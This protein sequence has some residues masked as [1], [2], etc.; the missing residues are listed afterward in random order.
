MN[1]TPPTETL[2]LAL[3][4]SG[5]SVAH[6]GFDDDDELFVSPFIGKAIV[7]RHPGRFA[8]VHIFGTIG[9]GWASLYLDSLAPDGEDEAEMKN[10]TDA[11]EKRLKGFGE[12]AWRGYLMEVGRAFE[13]CTGVPTQCHL[14]PEGNTNEEMWSILQ[15]MASLGLGRGRVAVDVTHS[16]R[17]L[18]LFFFAILLYFNALDD[19]VELGEVFY[20]KYAK[21]PSRSVILRL[22]ALLDLTRWTDAAQ[23]LRTYGDAGPLAALMPGT[24]IAEAAELFSLALMGNAA[25]SIRASAQ[26]L[27]DALA[28]HPLGD[29]PAF[30]LVR[31]RLQD[32]PARLADAPSDWE[33]MLLVSEH[34]LATRRYAL[35]ILNLWEAG[36]VR[37]AEVVGLQRLE[38]DDHKWCV[39]VARR[40]FRQ[41][42][43][44]HPL[45][46][47]VV[48]ARI[49]LSASGDMRDPEALALEVRQRIN[50]LSIALG[51]PTAEDAILRRAEAIPRR[52]SEG[53]V[54]QRGSSGA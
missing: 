50:H 39:R 4:A 27:L 54:A 23:K 47:E 44:L 13:A 26:T 29:P 5:Y 34:H 31:P 10:R 6:Y 8:T 20:G 53:R 35:A 15:T 12:D 33:A 14:I 7:N 18:P 41:M 24:P 32:L 45:R 9:S 38:E 37:V 48:H 52:R 3:G 43:K 1:P 46:N 42:D 51:A 16:F 21:A 30:D 36:V 11:E 19:D 2:L 49:G 40:A 25:A 22:N 17:H 28:A